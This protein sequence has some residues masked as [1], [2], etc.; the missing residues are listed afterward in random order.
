MIFTCFGLMLHALQVRA[1]FM[2]S[3]RRSDL[4]AHRLLWA[5]SSEQRPPEEAFSPSGAKRSGWQPP[6][7]TGLWAASAATR[8]AILSC[9][10]ALQKEYWAAEDGHFSQVGAVAASRVG[11]SG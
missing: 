2:A 10:S 5:L 3:A 9:L 11:G 4:F 7:D 6:K 1:F 8:K